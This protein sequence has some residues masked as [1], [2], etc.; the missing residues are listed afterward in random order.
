[1][2]ATKT[3]PPAPAAEPVL[4]PRADAHKAGVALLDSYLAAL[5]DLGYQKRAVDTWTDPRNQHFVR[6]AYCNGEWTL[7]CGYLGAG[8]LEVRYSVRATMPEVGQLINATLPPP[9]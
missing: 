5:R 9:F 8:A 4:P 1:M 7:T 3:A 6:H 2:T